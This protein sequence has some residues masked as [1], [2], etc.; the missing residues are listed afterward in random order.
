MKNIVRRLA[1]I[2]GVLACSGSQSAFAESVAETIHTYGT[3]GSI[4][5]ASVVQVTRA[6]GQHEL[7]TGDPVA[8]GDKIITDDKTTMTIHCADG[9]VLVVGRK[10]NLGIEESENAQRTARIDAGT[11]RAIVSK[12]NAE[13]ITDKKKFRFFIKTRSATLGVRGTDFV[14]SADPVTETSELHTLEGTVEVAKDETTIVTT[15]GEKVIGGQSVTATPQEITPP[16]VFDQVRFSEQMKQTQ[17][18]LAVPATQPTPAPS[19]SPSPEPSPSPSPE[20]EVDLE[21]S[22]SSLRSID[23]SYRHIDSSNSSGLSGGQIDWTPM[24]QIISHW[25]ALRGTVGFFYDT[26]GGLFPSVTGEVFKIQLSLRLLGHLLLE[27]GPIVEQWNTLGTTG[28]PSVTVGWEFT[29]GRFGPLD[30]VFFSFSD[31]GHPGFYEDRITQQNQNQNCGMGPCNFNNQN[32]SLK[33]FR[34]GAGFKF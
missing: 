15:G 29:R 24:L 30:R 7:K 3:I 2:V 32:S 16:A 17:P 33:E 19:A 31:L 22:R 9:T 20:V 5:G 1:L 13:K 27:F 26:S 11:V 4:D 10:S 6:S 18:A 12:I 28:G 34:F 14:V 8:P 21:P 23:F 25:L